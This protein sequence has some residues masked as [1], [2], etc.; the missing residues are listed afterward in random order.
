MTLCSGR[1]RRAWGLPV[2]ESALVRGVLEYLELRGIFAWRNN[3]GSILQRRGPK[4]YRI[5]L[6]P[7]GAPDIIGVLGDGRFLGIE[8]KKIGGRTDKDRELA[9]QAFQNRLRENRAVVFVARTL[10]DVQDGLAQAGY[11]GPVTLG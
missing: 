6:A 10:D 2:A 8:C 5:K 1:S 4:T 9:Q 7:E 3:S 11:V